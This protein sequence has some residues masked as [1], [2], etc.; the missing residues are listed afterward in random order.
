LFFQ[1][2][3][4]RFPHEHTDTSGFTQFLKFSSQNRTKPKQLSGKIIVERN[5][6]SVNKSFAFRVTKN[7][8]ATRRRTGKAKIQKQCLL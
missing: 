4:A 7:F 2:V 3:L 8:T 5:Q 6:D 1:S